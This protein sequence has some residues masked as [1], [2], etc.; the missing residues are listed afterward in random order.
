MT[1]T[2]IK[3]SLALAWCLRWW[4]RR[5]GRWLG[6]DLLSEPFA[7]IC[8]YA[9]RQCFVSRADKTFWVFFDFLIHWCRS[10][11]GS[12][13]I[14][15]AL[16]SFYKLV[17][18]LLEICRHLV[19]RALLDSLI[20]QFLNYFYV[21]RRLEKYTCNAFFVGTKAKDWVSDC[22]NCVASL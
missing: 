3:S 6:F 20:C 5:Y 11:Y 9:I 14:F 21:V 12:R 13:Y 4:T 22:G 18:S 2:A 8:K 16:D 17:V 15:N 1:T 10:F 7:A 19:S